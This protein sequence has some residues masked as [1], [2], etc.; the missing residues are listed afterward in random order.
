[1]AP[2]SVFEYGETVLDEVIVQIQ[3]PDVRSLAEQDKEQFFANP[4]S[5]ATWS[6]QGIDDAP[7][8]TLITMLAGAVFLRYAIR[9]GHP[10]PA[11][12]AATIG[13]E[14]RNPLLM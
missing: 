9:P 6:W 14:L 8:P 11:V 5:F 3:D 10:Q 12:I 7:W 2:G 13:S 1:M 4:A